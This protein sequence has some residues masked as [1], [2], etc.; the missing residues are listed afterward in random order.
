MI[1]IKRSFTVYS[2]SP[3]SIKIEMSLWIARKSIFKL[4]S[5]QK[6]RMRR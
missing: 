6:G 5:I 3:S 1:S 2:H 4:V